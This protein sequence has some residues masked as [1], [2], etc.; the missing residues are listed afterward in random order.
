MVARYAKLPKN[1]P[2]QYHLQDE[3]LLKKNDL[4]VHQET[5]EIFFYFF[6]F[7]TW[8]DFYPVFF[9]SLKLKGMQVQLSKK[10]I[11]EFLSGKKALNHLESSLSGYINI[12]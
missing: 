9:V 1:Q 10:Q 8:R 11:S 3:V 2:T 4:K 7:S 6:Y 5:F 12:H